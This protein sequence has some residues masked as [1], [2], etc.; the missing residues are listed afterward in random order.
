M[1]VKIC[2]SL[3]I[4]FAVILF[5][6]CGKSDYKEPQSVI[7]CWAHPTYADNAGGKVI[8][9]YER[10]GSLPD[11]SDGIEFL[12]NAS[13]IERKNAGWCGTP[14]IAYA[15]FSGN[16]HVQNENMIIDVAYWGG[17]EHRIWKIIEVTNATLKIEVMLQELNSKNE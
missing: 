13:L 4:V 7:G 16:W 12:K 6:S 3:A 11:N 10:M 5:V 9:S 2:F 8:I 17:M 14:P 1:K 15:D